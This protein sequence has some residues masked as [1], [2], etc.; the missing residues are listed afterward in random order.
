MYDTRWFL[1]RGEK[2]Y[3]WVPIWAFVTYSTLVAT[4]SPGCHAFGAER[5]EM[6][7]YCLIL[8]YL[9]GAG[10]VESWLVCRVLGG[11]SMEVGRG[12]GRLQV[13]FD[14]GH[15]KGACLA[16]PVVLGCPLGRR[17]Q[18]RAAPTCLVGV[19]GR[20]LLYVGPPPPGGPANIL[21]LY[22]VQQHSW[23]VCVSFDIMHP[24]QGRSLRSKQHTSAARLCFLGR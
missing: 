24:G 8:F 19:P 6:Y 13:L 16:H 21:L 22:T 3:C 15:I 9:K 2:L 23:S 20:K 11:K 7:G 1:I 12:G 4:Q 10:W 17:Q 5:E 18:C 14:D